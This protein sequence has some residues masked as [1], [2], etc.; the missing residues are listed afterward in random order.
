MSGRRIAVFSGQG[1]V[2]K[3]TVVAAWGA[4]AARSG[5]KTLLIDLNVGMRNLDIRLGLESRI[6]FDLGD[7]LEGLCSPEQ[8]LVKERNSGLYLLS[9]PALRVSERI[10]EDALAAL[11]EKLAEDFEWVFMDTGPGIGNTVSAAA[12]S[13]DQAVLLTRADDGGLRAA[14][15]MTELIRR[16]DLSS[17]GLLINV[18]D[19]AAIK[20]GFQ[21]SPEKCGQLLDIPV[22]EGIPDD[23]M[24]R[25]SAWAKEPAIG[26]YPG[27]LAIENALMRMKDDKKPMLWHDEG[28]VD[29]AAED[30]TTTPPVRTKDSSGFWKRLMRRKEG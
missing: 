6:V 15:R 26:I 28:F 29:A 19:T 11:T 30:C 25:R 13:A 16:R 8:A 3:T 17:P 18:V 14:E 12:H 7:V 24:I 9:A 5:E 23:P 1:G 10:D 22:L 20:E 21:Y 27:A 2:G 4:L